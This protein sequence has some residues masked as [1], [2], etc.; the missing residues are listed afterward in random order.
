LLDIY[1]AKTRIIKKIN[2]YYP[3][4]RATKQNLTTIFAT[5]QQY[6]SYPTLNELIENFED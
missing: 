4:F 5:I 2:K 6:G 1:H 3:D